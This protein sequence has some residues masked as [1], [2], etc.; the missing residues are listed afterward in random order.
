[1][2]KIRRLTLSSVPGDRR[3]VNEQIHNGPSGMPAL[4]RG[5][6]HNEAMLEQPPAARFVH[7]ATVGDLVEGRVLAAR[8]DAEG[9]EVR[10]HSPAL[11]P[12]P[13]TVGQMAETQIWVLSD[14]VQEASEILL[15]AEVNVALAPVDTPHGPKPSLP[16]EIRIIALV[17]AVVVGALWVLRVIRMF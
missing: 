17:V 9:I 3:L 4:V 8:L 5:N 13:V 16:V 6:G 1:M 2:P 11:G 12:Y 7:V 14:R 15:D 10:V